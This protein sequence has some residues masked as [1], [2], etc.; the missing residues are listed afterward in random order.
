[1]P[2][3]ADPDDSAAPAIAA[4]AWDSMLDDILIESTTFYSTNQSN[5]KNMLFKFKYL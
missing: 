5:R 3:F 1:M 4:A 2:F